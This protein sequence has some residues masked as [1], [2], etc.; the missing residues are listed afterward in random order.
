MI[1]IGNRAHYSAIGGVENSIRSLIKIASYKNIPTTIV[2]R[3]ALVGEPLGAG[4]FELPQ[5][6]QLQTYKDDSF[7]SPIKRLMSMSSGGIVL[8]KLYERLY[9]KFPDAIVVARHHTHVTA[10]KAAGFNVVRYLV[11]SLIRSQLKEE[12]VDVSWKLRL[13]FLLHSI[14]DGYAQQKAMS[15]AEL[16]VFSCLMEQQVRQQMKDS[17][18]LLSIKIVKPGID[19]ARFY[20][21]SGQERFDLR[22]KLG[23][24]HSKFLFL[25]VGRLVKAKGIDYL[26]SAMKDMP[27][28]CLAVLVGE[29]EQLPTI[30]EKINSNGLGHKIIYA[31]RSSR[32]E[33]FYQA[34]D[35]FVMSSTYEPLGQTILESAACGMRIAAFSRSAGVKTATHE[36]DID[37]LIDYASTLDGQGLARAMRRS[38]NASVSR[39][40]A[41]EKNSAIIESWE[42]LW[43]MLTIKEQAH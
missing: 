30:E 29:G 38:I 4:E 35:V 42:N 11:P 6:I 28:D 19:P 14:V 34:C 27:E 2:C 20:V 39:N 9:S 40:N 24:P 43:E 33:D 36:L 21:P 3:E 31:G 13:H 41:R 37:H 22:C 15:N 1:I 32:V 26:V 17:K 5:N 12:A 7:Y 10:A 16:F 8:S 18:N 23:L 25:F